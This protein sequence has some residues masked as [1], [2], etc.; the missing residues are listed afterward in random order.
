[1]QNYKKDLLT[2]TLHR[3]TQAGIW[4]TISGETNNQIV[5]LLLTIAPNL[6]QNSF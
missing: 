3:Q 4:Y 5:P 6:R 1:M 2:Q